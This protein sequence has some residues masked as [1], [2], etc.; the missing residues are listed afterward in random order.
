M[1]G[2]PGTS[3]SM[4]S[5]KLMEVDEASFEAT[6]LSSPVP[7]LVDFTAVWC[8]PCRAIAP[9]LEVIAAKYE[10]RLRVVKCDADENAQLAAH[11]GVR[12]LPTLLLFKGGQVV[13]QLVGAVPRARIEGLVDGVVAGAAA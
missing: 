10:G 8:P 2:G 6:T 9:H 5:N 13:G 12:G 1:P 3:S 11:Y 7:V 4:S